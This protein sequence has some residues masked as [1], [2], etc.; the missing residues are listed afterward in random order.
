M[1]GLGTF[2][3]DSTTL[4]VELWSNWGGWPVAADAVRVQELQGDGGAD[5]DFH[6]ASTSPTID[7]GDP[8]SP[9]LS[10]PEPNDGRANIGADGN[11]AQA[12]TS[13]AQELQ[14]LSPNSGLEKY[15]QGQ[16]VA[17]Q[18]R[19][20]GL[21][22]NNTVFLMNVGGGAVDN[23]LANAYQTVSGG[24]AWTSNVIDTSGL[25]DP[26]PEAVYQSWVYANSGVGN[27]LAYNLPVP[28]GTY[29]ITL[30]F[31]DPW[32]NGPGE[33][34]FDIKLNGTT[35]QSDYDIY[36]AA[37]NNATALTFAVTA[38][39]GQGIHLELVNDPDNWNWGAILS[40]IELTQAN[41]AGVANPTVDLQVSGD[42]GA[43][44]NTIATG[45]TMDGYGR[46]SYNWTVPA[47]QP[48]GQYLMRVVSDDFAGVS[49][50][51]AGTFQ[52]ANGGTSF[53]VNGDSTA[54]DQYTTAVGN[55]LNDGKTPSTPMA[56]L[57][58]LINV[59][60]PGAGDTIYVDNGTYDL[61]SNIVLTAA[62]SGLTIVGPTDPGTAAVLNRGN[63]N[64]GAYAID[65]NGANDVTLDNLSVTGAYDGIVTYNNSGLTVTD[66]SLYGNSYYGIYVDGSSSGV[67]LAD[68]SVDGN[69]LTGICI[70]GSGATVI[71]DTVY[72][73]GGS[74]V[75]HC[76]GIDAYGWADTISDNN[77]YGNYNEGIVVNNGDWNAG[78][79]SVVSGNT[80]DNNLWGG[81][82]NE[83]DA[84]SNVLVTGNTVYGNG[85]R[86]GIFV[87]NG[88]TASDNV[89]YGN[90]D[91]IVGGSSASVIDNR[92]FANTDAGI[93]VNY[94]GRLR[95]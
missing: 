43:T 69:G 73:N 63:G 54:G 25:T 36:A 81:S 37:G 62:D 1:A 61:S 84:T 45:L 71:A 77:V 50:T 90:Y 21:T 11:T 94:W 3:P 55:N 79:Q 16:S 82:S 49:G 35:V 66:S 52:I 6:V 87:T 64:S 26:A 9:Y 41:P 40:G 47:N 76:D 72:A 86:T 39:G 93:V 80:V 29:T 57:A 74:Y 7:A 31:A 85:G 12:A 32:A 70:N 8:N 17:V 91:G 33:R 4:S 65:L 28:D 22:Q 88:A 24:T 56:S 67:T 78:C 53:Y 27:E 68:S 46:G 75:E 58:A 2:R 92:S 89:V 51:S 38:S 20:F 60:H 10:E 18:W 23:W 34:V 30:E 44:W 13:P 42:N 95:D 14:M 48:P 59:Y 19:S 5:D 83:I 15:Q